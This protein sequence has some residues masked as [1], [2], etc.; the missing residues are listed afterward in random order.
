MDEAKNAVRSECRSTARAQGGE[1]AIETTIVNGDG[2]ASEK[3]NPGACRDGWIDPKNVDD[4]CCSNPMGSGDWGNRRFKGD[5]SN[6]SPETWE[7]PND[8]YPMII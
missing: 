3:S 6:I 5:E 4:S 7:N 2:L 1:D 8:E